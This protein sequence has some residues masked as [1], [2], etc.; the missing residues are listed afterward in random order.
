MFVQPVRETRLQQSFYFAFA[1]FLVSMTV[2]IARS[3]EITSIPAILLLGILVALDSFFLLVG[4]HIRPIRLHEDGIE[5]R[6]AFRTTFWRHADLRDI[7]L[8]RDHR[9]RPS[10][11][12][13]VRRDGRLFYA[14][15]MW[16]SD[17]SFATGR[18]E[19]IASL[20][21]KGVTERGGGP[22]VEWSPRTWADIQPLLF[23]GAIAA[24]IEAMARARGVSSIDEAFV[25]RVRSEDKTQRRWFAASHSAAAQRALKNS[26][27]PH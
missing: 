9:G 7:H 6:P 12:V 2:L 5:F 16:S 15:T 10:L 24:R 25:Q 23:R 3:I 27:A 21:E 20:M 22:L 19:E 14:G 1:A 11:L 4:S 18:L 26:K 17:V 8:V 13:V